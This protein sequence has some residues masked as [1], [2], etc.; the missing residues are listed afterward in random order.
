[1]KAYSA[2]KAP[3]APAAPTD[4]A[5]ELSSYDSAEPTLASSAPATGAPV[6]DETGADAKAFL[7]FLE[8]DLPKPEAH[9]H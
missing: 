2:P 1:M 9:H 3:S 5:S 6:E 4:L 7:A 8:Q